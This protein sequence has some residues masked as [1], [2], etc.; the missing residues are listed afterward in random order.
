[1]LYFCKVCSSEFLITRNTTSCACSKNNPLIEIDGYVVPVFAKQKEGVNE[2][3][4]SLAAEIHDNAMN[5]LHEVHSSS[6]TPFRQKLAASVPFPAVKD[7]LILVTSCGAGNDLPYLFDRF[8]H[9]IFFVQDLAQEMLEAAIQRHSK[10]LNPSQFHFSISDACDLPFQ[11]NYFDVVYHFGGVNLFNDIKKGIEEMHRVAKVGAFVIFGD[12]GIAPYLYNSEISKVLIKNNPLYSKAAP[13]E[14]IPPYVRDFKL[15]YLFNNCFYLISYIKDDQ[16]HI[17]L[18]IQ[19]LGKRGGSLRTRFYGE[20]EGI[21][22]DLRDDIFRK[23]QDLGI[24]RVEL[25]ET[26]LRQGLTNASDE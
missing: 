8:P 14:F 6:E 2:F 19:H 1:M 12:E 25:L 16:H 26:L 15:E 23:A 17:N 4:I 24:S 5:W 22:P 21:D 3:S 9:G 10:N 18:D 13:V 20:L 7:P 11:D